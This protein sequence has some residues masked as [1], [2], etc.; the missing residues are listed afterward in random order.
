MKHAKSS[1]LTLLWPQITFPAFYLQWRWREQKTRVGRVKNDHAF[2]PGVSKFQDLRSSQN[3]VKMGVFLKGNGCW[4]IGGLGHLALIVP[5]GG[6]S[7]DLSK[8]PCSVSSMEPGLVNA[9]SPWSSAFLGDAQLS[10]LSATQAHKKSGNTVAFSSVAPMPL[11]HKNRK[12]LCGGGNIWESNVRFWG[13]WIR[14]F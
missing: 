6:A 1:E 10:L 11:H 7:R 2:P 3:G 14:F 12:Q 8:P 9:F 13:N 4:A 5:G